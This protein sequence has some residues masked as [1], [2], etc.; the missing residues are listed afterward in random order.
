MRETDLRCQDAAL[1]GQLSVIFPGKDGGAAA[2][3]GE[4]AV[5]EKEGAGHALLGD[6]T[7]LRHLAQAGLEE[8][9]AASGGAPG[10]E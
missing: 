5:K 8:G 10:E 6:A 2:A 1:L 7:L 3:G 9:E 4:L